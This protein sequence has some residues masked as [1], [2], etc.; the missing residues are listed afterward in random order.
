MAITIC[1]LNFKGGVGKTTVTV[2]LGAAL[3]RLKKKVLIIDL[4][5]Q[6]TATKT[7]AAKTPYDGETI[8]DFLS[9]KTQSAFAYETSQKNLD[10]VPSS[11]EMKFIEMELS[12]KREREHILEKFIHQVSPSYDYILIDCPPGQGIVTDNAMV[13]AQKI[14]IPVKC[15]VYSMFGLHDIIAESDD[16]KAGSNPSLEILG[17]IAN[18][19]DGRTCINRNISSAL[20]ESYPGMVLSTMIRKTVSLAEFSASEQSIFDYDAKSSAALDFLNLGKEVI[21]KTSSQ[22]SKKS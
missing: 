15:E 2:N 9:G 1:M 18:A 13:A 3:A 20:N 7:F 22:V 5:G 8:Y 12:R 11:Q 6:C 16:I 4:D 14:I 21:N 19:Y 17:I 10:Y